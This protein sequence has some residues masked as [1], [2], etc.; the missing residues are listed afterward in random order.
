MSKNMFFSQ[1]IPVNTRVNTMQYDKS[2]KPQYNM[3]VSC[4]QYSKVNTI[5]PKFYSTAS[6]GVQ[7]PESPFLQKIMNFFD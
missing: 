3:N 4:Q 2:P 6:Y 7:H 5:H 1:N